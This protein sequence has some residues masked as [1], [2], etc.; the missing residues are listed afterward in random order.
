[1]DLLNRAYAQL[2]DLFRSMTPGS[3]LTAG[4]LLAVVG[5][6][7]GYLFM[8]PA[9]QP[10]VDLMNGAPIQASQLRTIEAALGKANLKTYEVR[11]TKIFVPRGEEAAYMAALTD[12]KALPQNLGWAQREAV[13]ETSFFDVGSQRDRNRQKIAVQDALSTAIR[14]KP[15]IEDAAVIYD[16]DTKPGFGHEK[17]MTALVSVRP[18][19]NLPLDERQVS[20]IRQIVVAGKA[21]M[22]PENVT[23]ADLNGRTWR[24]VEEGAMV[25]DKLYISLKRAYEQDLKTKIL[26]ALCRYISGVTVEV[27]MELGSERTLREKHATYDARLSHRPNAVANAPQA[28]LNAN[29][30]RPQV[31]APLASN[32]TTVLKA[33]LDDGSGSRDPTR[34]LPT[35]AAANTPSERESDQWTPRLAKVS[36]GIPDSY[37]RQIWEIWEKRSHGEAREPSKTSDATT[38]DRIRAEESAKI[39]K[40]VAQLLPPVEGINNPT[41]LVVVTRFDDLPVK[42][43]PPAAW[44]QNAYAWLRQYG[45][46]LALVGLALVS[47]LVLRSMARAGAAEARTASLLAGVTM[48]EDIPVPSEEPTESIPLHHARRASSTSA[49]GRDELSELVGQDPNAAAGILRTWVG[50]SR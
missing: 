22:K 4:L 21:G 13:N 16:E 28:A 35:A 17:Q 7:V 43:L 32:V 47:L 30:P 45:G 9:A 46:M 44:D 42:E 18:A 2:Y 31:V 41:E 34:S 36:I 10:Q 15:G 24:G 12:A 23:V 14:N 19:G 26:N 38:L 25:G 8:H 29:F 33:V 49:V 27:N 3:R 40:H 6:S 50:N 11:G 5:I 48:T 1:M 20:D 39:Q 37:F